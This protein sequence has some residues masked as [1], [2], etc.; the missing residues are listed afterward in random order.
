VKSYF[1]E[2]T[3]LCNLESYIYHK[4]DIITLKPGRENAWLDA[5]VEKCLQKL[6]CEA[7]QVRA[8][9]KRTLENRLHADQVLTAYFLY[10][11]KCLGKYI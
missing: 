7:I 3:P 4:E 10:S 8:M 2:E 11:C 5:A 9:V 1:D 6:P